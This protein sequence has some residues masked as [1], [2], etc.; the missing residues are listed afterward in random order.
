MRAFIIRPFGTKNDINFDEVERLL[1][2]PALERIGAEGRTTIDIVQTGNIRVDMFRRLLTA[3]LV[4][5]DLSIHNANVFY[6]LGIRHALRDHGTFMLRCDA[7]KFPFDLQTDRYFVYRK[8]DPGASLAALV[9]ALR[10][11][12]DAIEK[13]A[14]AK[15]SPVFASLPNLTE[16]DPSLFNPVPQDFGEEVERAAANKQAGDLALFSYEVR[17]MEWE[18]RGWRT[19]GT[20][21]FNIKALAGA[22]ETWESVR[23]LEPNDLEANILL[24]TVYERLG[25]LTRSTQALERALANKNI[26]RDQRAETY[27]LLARNAKT[28]WRSEWEIMPPG[29]R[30]A[31]ALRSPYLNDS[32]RNYER[33]FAEDINHFYSGLNALAMLSVMIELAESLP[34]VWGELF[35][36]DEE[37]AAALASHKVRAGKLAAAVEVSLSATISRLRREG[38]QDVWAEISEADLRYLTLKRPGRVAAAYRDAL[39]GAPDFARDSVRNQ[40]ALYK[41]LGVLAGNLAEVVKV[42]GEPPP[43]PAP[44]AQPAAASQH[45]RVLIFAGHMIDAPGR[46]E[47]RFPADKEQAARAK[48]REAVMKEM[49]MG[50]GV[51]SG[52]AGGA[53]GGDILFQE[54]CA[55]L[56]IETR[57]YLAIPPREYVKNS[58]QKA[59]PAWV[60]RFWKLY[61]RHQAQKQVRVL[62]DATDEGEYLPAW[63]REKPD[64][65]IWQ[66]NNLWMLFNALDEGCDPKSDDPNLT[67]IALW[68]GAGGDG[69]GGTGDLVK[70]VEDLGA[71]SVVINTKKEFGL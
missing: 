54:V 66:R 32:F 44:G 2:A 8:E 35:E 17:G 39:A 53:S 40:L 15:D 61:E 68:D 29:E 65:S 34:D 45:K 1:I 16:P 55:E 5:A 38:R 20:A 19:A 42:V 25:D 36:T 12:Q 28:R 49:N 11:T 50:T 26:T 10:R 47:P 57:L 24:G 9:E 64:Y 58:V 62:G 13:D 52:Y 37:A 6:E 31:T 67:L 33:A 4:I 63:L 51:A 43:L 56:G 46:K 3:D 14:A 7:D 70:K 71:R 30:P 69:P 59:G 23:R 21:Q 60:E 27:S 22:R 18:M 41:N 48:I